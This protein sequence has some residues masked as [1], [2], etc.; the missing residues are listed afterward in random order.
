MQN[1]LTH[2]L[3][4]GMFL[5]FLRQIFYILVGFSSENLAGAYYKRGETPER[6]PFFLSSQSIPRSRLRSVPTKF[7]RIYP[8][9][10]CFDLILIMCGLLS[11]M[12]GTGILVSSTKYNGKWFEE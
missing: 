12:F 10:F 11:S 4:P 8:I 2:I 6:S 7:I 1:S 9:A 5:W 3:A